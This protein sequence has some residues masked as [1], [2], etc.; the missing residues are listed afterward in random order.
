MKNK[1]KIFLLGLLTFLQI[2]GF[3]GVFVLNDMSRKRVGVNHH[4]IIRKREFIASFLNSEQV[5]LYK[6][7]LIVLLIVF[8]IFLVFQIVRRVPWWKLGSTIIVML[9]C[10]LLYLELIQATFI[11]LPIYTYVLMV[12]GVILV[13]EIFKVIITGFIKK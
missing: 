12:T 4:V 7:F 8:L 13:I 11:A 3:I 5:S 2:I 6:V 10:G 9:I 1:L